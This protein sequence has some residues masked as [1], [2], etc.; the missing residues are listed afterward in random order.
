MWI[1]LV[2]DTHCYSSVT[3]HAY[4]YLVYVLT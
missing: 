1:E 3:T 4:L 2:K